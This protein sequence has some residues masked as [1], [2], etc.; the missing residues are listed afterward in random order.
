VNMTLVPEIAAEAKA[1][2]ALAFRNGPIEDLHAGKLCPTC[3]DRPEFSHISDDEIKTV[4][5]AA[6]DA[7]YRLLWQRE[8]DPEKYQR[9]LAFGLRYARDWDDPELRGPV[10]E[11]IHPK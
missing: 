11:G 9:N 2:V 10:P 8:C 4:M 1:L 7:L 3:C 5:K 6:V